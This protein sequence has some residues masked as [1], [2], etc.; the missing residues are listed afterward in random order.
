[1]WLEY[2]KERFGYEAIEEEFGF[3][4]YSL[5]H[6][7][8]AVQEI[9]I[10][11]EFRRSIKA[12]ELMNR[13]TQIARENGCIYLWTQVWLND[14]GASRAMR[15]N[16]AYGFKMTEASNNRIIMLKEIEGRE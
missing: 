4:L 14:K 11:P 7:Y 6:P 8:L 12:L 2:Q 5:N 16:L 13:I 10:K 1:M 9:Y 3:L 15:A